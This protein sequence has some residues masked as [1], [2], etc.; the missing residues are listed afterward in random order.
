MYGFSMELLFSLIEQNVEYQNGGCMKYVCS[1]G[2][3]LRQLMKYCS[4]ACEVWCGDGSHSCL[5]IM[6]TLP[7]LCRSYILEVGVENRYT[8]GQVCMYT[9]VSSRN[10]RSNALEPDRSQHKCTV[11]RV[12][13]QQYFSTTFVS[14]RFHSRTEKFRSRLI[15]LLFFY[16]LSSCLSQ[17]VYVCRHTGY[18]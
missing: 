7:D 8:C 3:S 18:K 14:F 17:K 16:F 11:A 12:T 13:C 6:Q 5:H 2:F 4:Q 15:F 9:R 10:P 1:F